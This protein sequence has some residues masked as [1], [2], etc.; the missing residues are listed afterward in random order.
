MWYPKCVTVLY[1]CL[2]N[3]HFIQLWQ[4][5]QMSGIW[6]KKLFSL[7]YCYLPVLIYHHSLNIKV[8]NNGLNQA[9]FLHFMFSL[10]R[11]F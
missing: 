8:F 6:E 5:F 7:L 11:F 9:Y 2:D 3:M 1:T 10:K 4:I